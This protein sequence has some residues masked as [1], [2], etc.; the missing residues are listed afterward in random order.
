MKNF[1]KIYVGNL[2]KLLN[3][4]E[5]FRQP[6]RKTLCV[7]GFFS[8]YKRTSHTKVCNIKCKYIVSYILLKSNNF[9]EIC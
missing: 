3:I 4:Y 2:R 8:V 5:D 1:I 7:R 9:I 6:S